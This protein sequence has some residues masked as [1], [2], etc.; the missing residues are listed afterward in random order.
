MGNDK[1]LELLQNLHTVLIE[2]LLD[3]V[4]SGEAKAG[5]LNVARQLL[6]DNGIECIPTANNPM[7]DLMSSLPDLDVIPALER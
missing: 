5:D 3:K 4:K 2:N 6:K 1:K 7:E